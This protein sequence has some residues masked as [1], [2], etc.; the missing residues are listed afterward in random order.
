MYVLRM[1]FVVYEVGLVHGGDLPNVKGPEQSLCHF[2]L[3]CF[4]FSQPTRG[5]KNGQTHFP[6]VHCSARSFE[7]IAWMAREA[8]TAP[9]PNLSAA[10]LWCRAFVGGRPTVSGGGEES[11]KKLEDRIWGWSCQ[12]ETTAGSERPAQVRGSSCVWKCA[13]GGP[14]SEANQCAR[15]PMKNAPGKSSDSGLLCQSPR[16]GT[17][18]PLQPP[19]P[20]G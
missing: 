10:A 8:M 4:P 2:L 16:G 9:S 11:Q 3:A 14:G 15:R 5:V 6:H 18:A 7:R 1:S 19:Q 17:K 13:Q 12:T 20:H